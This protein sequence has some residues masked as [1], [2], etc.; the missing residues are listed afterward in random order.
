MIREGDSGMSLSELFF[1]A[2]IAEAAAD[3]IK[4]RGKVVDT[5]IQNGKKTG[6]RDEK[7]R[8]QESLDEVFQYIEKEMNEY[9]LDQ[10]EYIK[11]LCLAFKRP[12]V[13]ETDKSYRN[14]IFVFGKEGT[15]R[16]YS[17]KVLA[18]L[19]AIKRITKE[20]LC[21]CQSRMRKHW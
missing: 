20:C 2:R 9:V 13:S 17:I 16:K 19:L 8:N 3:K 15:G 21:I 7:V 1:G 11:G 4:G 5:N 12:L 10:E 6:K 18:K 14:M